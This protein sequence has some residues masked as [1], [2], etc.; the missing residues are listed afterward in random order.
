MERLTDS[1]RDAPCWGR[2]PLGPGGN[3]VF[4]EEKLIGRKLD[5]GLEAGCVLSEGLRV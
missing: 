4:C 1:F 2:D 3:L 5:F